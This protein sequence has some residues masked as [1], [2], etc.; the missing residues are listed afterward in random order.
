MA[1]RPRY[2][3][4]PMDPRNLTA[5]VMATS[6]WMLAGCATIGT[7]PI[8][9]EEKL[10][11]ESTEEV[12]A[13]GPGKPI[14]VVEGTL[15]KFRA[16][17]LC[18]NRSV[19]HMEH[20]ET[21]QRFI[22]G[23]YPWYVGGAGAAALAAGSIGMVDAT[24]VYSDDTS[25][26]T[27]NSTG[28]DKAFM[29]NGALLAAG[30][31]AGTLLLVDMVRA[32]GTEEVLKPREVAADPTGD[33]FQCAQ[34]VHA[35]EPVIALLGEEHVALGTTSSAGILEVDLDEALPATFHGN[36]IKLALLGK[37]VLTLDVTP[38]QRVREKKIWSELD[39]AK[40][41]KPTTS[42]SCAEVE[43]FLRQF[44]TG[45]HST[46]AAELLGT[47]KP[48]LAGMADDEAWASSQSECGKYTFN[49]PEDA[50]ASCAPYRSYL[51]S[52][53][54]GLHAAEAKETLS[55]VDKEIAKMV[56][57]A[58]AAERKRQREQEA[59]ERASAAQEHKK[60]QAGC[61]MACAGP[62]MQDKAMCQRGCYALQCGDGDQCRGECDMTCA[63][64]RFS[65]DHAACVRDCR[66]TKECGRQQ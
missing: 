15:L 63:H 62:A 28:Q 36:E 10:I 18:Q 11:R 20:V 9:T 51:E 61:R 16:V 8:K 53:P 40:C 1:Q 65:R 25:S 59:A 27:Y 31:A 46:E 6:L 4:T 48:V 7:R 17:G 12:L 43:A 54:N 38:I 37:S 50:K 13:D 33:E 42:H 29:A 66:V 55:A 44:P 58:E 3:V 30:V 2:V 24:N 14:A 45:G 47:A 19:R 39:L 34:K 22:E 52:Y 49:S 56:L 26:R 60:C 21:R 35:G 32:S 23:A 57:A 41:R 5:T 64:I